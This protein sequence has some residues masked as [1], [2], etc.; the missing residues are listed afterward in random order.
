LV[1]KQLD[2]NK[3]A[4]NS[5]FTNQAKITNFQLRDLANKRARSNAAIR[6]DPQAIQDSI[7]AFLATNGVNE[8]GIR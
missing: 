8:R 5:N 3:Q 6:N 1:R 2:Q 7:D 4:F